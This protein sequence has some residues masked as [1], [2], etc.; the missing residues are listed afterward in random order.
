MKIRKST[1]IITIIAAVLISAMLTAIFINPFGAGAWGDLII[2][3]MGGNAKELSRFNTALYFVKERF[4]EETDPKSLTDFAIS[5]MVDSL[6][7]DYSEFMVSDAAEEFLEDVDGNYTGVGLY[8]TRGDDG[9]VT[10]ISPLAGSPAYDAH[11]STGDK[12]ISVDGEEVSGDDLSG[13]SDKMKGVAGTPVVISVLKADSGTTEEITLNRA[14]ITIEVVDGK[15]LDGNIG[16]ISVSQFT[17]NT[18]NQFESKITELREQGAVSLIIDLRGNPGGYMDV[19]IDMADMFMDS[20]IITYTEDKSGRRR[21]YNTGE[22]KL[23]IPVVI[24]TNGGSASASEIF[25]GALHDS[26]CAYLV[27]GKTYGKGVVQEVIMLGDDILKL[28]T[29]RYYT[30]SGVCV[31]GIGIEPDLQVEMS[32]EDYYLYARGDKDV[33]LRAAV[34]YIKSQYGGTN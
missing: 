17:R 14:E 15:L 18:T 24:L 27:G 3:R 29:A 6:N 31:N 5:G 25:A 22:D 20:G 16:Y 9:L 1:F 11:I 28:T 10:V 19:A 23:D 7:D 32:Y 2:A 26:G 34:N 8:I 4:Y 33:Q 21:V 12:I 13:A 30:P